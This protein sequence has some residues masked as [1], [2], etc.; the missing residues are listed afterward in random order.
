MKDRKEYKTES[1]VIVNVG[2]NMLTREEV[3]NIKRNKEDFPIGYTIPANAYDLLDDEEKK[4]WGQGWR[5][6]LNC[7]FQ[8]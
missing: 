3:I 7:Y 6:V 4:I 5:G 8:K 2:E 1:K